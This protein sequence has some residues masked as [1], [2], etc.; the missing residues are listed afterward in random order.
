MHS[1]LIIVYLLSVIECNVT[2]SVSDDAFFSNG[3][4]CAL[5]ITW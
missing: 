4:Y 2:L 1:V 3:E 5:K